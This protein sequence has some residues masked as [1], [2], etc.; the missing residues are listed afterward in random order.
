MKLARR[1]F[2]AG[3]AALTARPAFAADMLSLDQISTYLNSFTTAQATF[4]QR[5]ADGSVSTGRLFLKRPGRA[6]FE[7]D[8]PNDAL[9]LAGNRLPE[10][11]TRPLR[12]LDGRYDLDD[13]LQDRQVCVVRW[14]GA[15][16]T[17][18]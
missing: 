13:A 1:T 14:S 11:R 8:P 6:R 10:S 2:M 12:V 17:F 7:Y 18:T 15:E 16:R 3:L 9:V 5:N 4:R